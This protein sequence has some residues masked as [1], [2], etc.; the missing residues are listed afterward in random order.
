MPIVDK[1]ISELKTYRGMNPKPLDFDNYWERGIDEM[2]ALGT[3]YELR[4]AMFQMA[5]VRCDDLYF[6]GVH[7]ARVY[8]KLLRPVGIVDCPALVAFHGYSENSGDWW[9]NLHMLLPVLW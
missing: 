5:G 3:E 2:H 7:G 8:A 9:I 4:P 1:P 6:R